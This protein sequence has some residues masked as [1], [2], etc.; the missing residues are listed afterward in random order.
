MLHPLRQRRKTYVED[1]TILCIF[2][3][4]KYPAIYTHDGIIKIHTGFTQQVI[5]KTEIYVDN[6][7]N[8]ANGVNKNILPATEPYTGDAG[9]YSDK[10]PPGSVL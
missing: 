9:Y 6:C 4:P 2:F 3:G 1:M 8:Q 10:L 5:F 7:I